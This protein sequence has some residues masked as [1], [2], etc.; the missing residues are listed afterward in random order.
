VPLGPPRSDPIPLAAIAFLCETDC[1]S[2]PRDNSLRMK[3]TTSNSGRRSFSMP[4]R[5]QPN[6]PADAPRRD[7]VDRRPVVPRAGSREA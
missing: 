7:H 5:R 2:D 4:L 1:D 6:R 3:P